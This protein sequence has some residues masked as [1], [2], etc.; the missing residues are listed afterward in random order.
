MT[1][2]DTVFEANNLLDNKRIT[3]QLLSLSG[4]PHRLY[5]MVPP[6]QSE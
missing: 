4:C 6:L 2:H 1:Y 5:S 3:C